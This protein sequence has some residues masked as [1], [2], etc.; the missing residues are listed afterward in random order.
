VHLRLQVRTRSC[1]CSALMRP[2]S[3]WR[4]ASVPAPIVQTSDQALANHKTCIECEAL[5]RK[6]GYDHKYGPVVRGEGWEP[7][8]HKLLYPPAILPQLPASRVHP[9]TLTLAEQNEERRRVYFL[10]YA[11]TSNITREPHYPCRSSGIQWGFLC[12]GSTDRR[13]E[14]AGTQSRVEIY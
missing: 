12:I 9:C 5:R 14:V 11:M 4:S 3:S 7:S 6:T 1:L 10:Q 2:S 13:E 8:H